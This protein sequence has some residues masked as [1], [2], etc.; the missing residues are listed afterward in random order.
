MT[1]RFPPGTKGCDGVSSDSMFTFSSSQYME[2]VG[3]RCFSG[4]LF[5]LLGILSAPRFRSVL[6]HWIFRC[7]LKRL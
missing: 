4:R 6:S 5:E 3:R 2:K 7:E 1:K